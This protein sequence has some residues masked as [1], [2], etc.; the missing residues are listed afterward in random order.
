MRK[1]VQA[2]EQQGPEAPP[3]DR[4][5]LTRFVAD[6]TKLERTAEAGQPAAI[7]FPP[8]ELVLWDKNTSIRDNDAAVKELAEGIKRFGFT[9]TVVA[10]ASRRMVCAGNTATRAALLLRMPLIPVRFVNLSDAEAD[11]YALA[12]NKLAELSRWKDPGLNSLLANLRK[13]GTKIEGLGF[14]GKELGKRLARNEAVTNREETFKESKKPKNPK[15]KMGDLYKMGD[16]FL[17]CADTFGAD[18]LPKLLGDEVGKVQAVITDPPFAIYGS[19]T[20]IGADIAD[21]SMVRPFFEKV[22]SRCFEVLEFFGHAYICCDWRSYPSV[23]EGAKYGSL[24]PKN[25]LVWDKGN[26]GL[27]SSYSNAYELAGFFAKLPPA[28]AMKSTQVRGQRQIHRSNIFR[29]NR[30]SGAE[31]NHNAAKPVEWIED[32]LGN[33]TDEGG[34]VVDFFAGGGPIFI[35]AEKQKRK[36]RATEKDPGWCDV[37]VARWEAFT[38]KRAE[39]VKSR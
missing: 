32:M 28:T 14:S 38:G 34:I 1:R 33:S 29:H 35:A 9:R 21:D 22:A 10:Q 26:S 6:I 31:R 27:G 18:T 3:I 20:G 12:D 39:L 17:L 4:H 30:V 15:T 25:L 7:W 5:T 13:A 23:W 24:S 8:S 2:E 16:H 11:A 36:A 37:I 19:S